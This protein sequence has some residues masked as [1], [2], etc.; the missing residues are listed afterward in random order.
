[1]SYTSPGAS[2]APDAPD[3]PGTPPDSPDTPDAPLDLPPAD[4]PPA[5]APPVSIAKPAPPPPGM[6]APPAF[7]PGPPPPP[8]PPYPRYY[9]PIPPRPAPVA[10]LGTAAMVL[11]GGVSAL[12]LLRLIADFD[13][14]DTLGRSW[15]AFHRDDDVGGFWAFAVLLLGIGFLAAIPVFLTWF[16]RVRTNAEVFAP[17]RHRQSPGMAI[18]A[19]FIPF[20]NWWIPKQITDDIVAVSDPS[21]GARPTAYGHPGAY[22]H[23]A[24][25]HPAPYARPGQGAVTAWWATWVASSV[26]SALGWLMLVAADEGDP[27]DGRAALLMFMLSDAALMAAGVCGIVMIRTI[28]TMQD[29]RLGFTRLGTHLP[30]PPP[31]GPRHW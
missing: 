8:P 20:A 26:L 4:A 11:F 2:G 17:G 13:L 31:A 10:G 18:G 14:Y 22:G 19:W 1:M 9:V 15:Y 29:L 25:Y 6:D 27:G 28:T 30:P 23:P 21:G 16:N 7:P 24:P 5:D 3:S 12:A